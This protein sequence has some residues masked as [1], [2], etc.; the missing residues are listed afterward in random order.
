MLKIQCSILNEVEKIRKILFLVPFSL[1]LALAPQAQAAQLFDPDHPVQ[2][3]LQVFEMSESF[4]EIFERL[5]SVKWAGRDIRIAIESLELLD[6]DVHIAVT[7]RRVV[8]VWR[9]SIVGNWPRPRENDWAAYGE[10]TTAMVIRLREH[11]PALRRLS[12]SGILEVVV[13]ALMRGIDENGRYIYSKRAQVAEDGRLLTSAGLEGIVDERGNFR[14]TGVFKG[15]PAADN[16]IRAGDLVFEINGRQLPD[17]KEGEI[18]AALSGFTSGTL[19]LLVGSESGQRN[20]TLR[21]A[22]VMIADADIVWKET[23]DSGILEIIVSRISDNSA[24]IINEALNKYSPSGVI[25]D[26]RVAH[27]DDE[28]SAAKIAGLFMGMQ[29]VMRIVETAREE[30]EITPGGN[31]VT[32]APVVVIVSGGTSGTAEAIAAAFHEN[33]R[34]ALIGTPTAARARLATRL[35]LRSGGQLEV[36]NRTIRTSIGREIDGRGIFPIVCL[37][38]IRN[39]QQQNA[40]FVNVL[41][42]DFGARDFNAEDIDPAALRRGCP[43]IRSGADEDAVSAAVAVKILTDGDV[44]NKLLTDS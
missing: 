13:S 11:M 29:P 22:T 24:A 10:I 14:V 17:M 6:R 39:T 32:D 36:L 21:R 4:A 20:V 33:G 9:D 1:F 7:D 18:A 3:G 42:G 37:S 8:L 25:L 15:S 2:D 19:R 34:G 44:Y 12:A 30:L 16:G 41:N 5:D 31:A 26:L 35:D 28:R 27:G 43:A 40:F 23:E 38:N